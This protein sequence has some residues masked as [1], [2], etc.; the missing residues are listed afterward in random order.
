[1]LRR[2]RVALY[3]PH[4]SEYS[5]RLAAGLARHCDV[6]LVLNRKDANR[7][8]SL[9]AIP[10]SASFELRIRDLSLR[11]SG[12]LG[13]PR[14]FL[15]VLTF[16]P[17]I[18]H[19]HESPDYYT[20]VLIEVLRLSRTPLVL[21]VHDA[22]P[23]SDG[24]SGTNRVEELLRGRMRSA[25]ALVTLH[26]NRCVAEF[27][28]TSPDFKGRLTAAMHGVLMVPPS[29]AAPIQPVTGRILLFGR[30][31]S[32]KGL[33]VFL[34]AVDILAKRG[35]QHQAVVA[36]RGPEMTRLAARIASAPT[37][38]AIDAYISPEETGVLFRSAAVVA[39][40]YK[41]ATQSGVLASAFGNHRAVVA[42]A[43]GGIPDIVEDGSNG[44]LVPPG[45]PV[46][47]ADALQR[48]LQ[49]PEV[50]AELTAG[51]ARTAAGAM[52]WDHIADE[53]HQAYKALIAC[54][55]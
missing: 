28:L 51:A 31:M 14:S 49:S 2:L 36:G 29:N 45:D 52:N 54:P 46:A 55:S 7:Q 44:I 53:V 20:A 10:V 25:A 26:G 24:G 19:C 1:M 17:D 38:R 23:H 50:L 30:M 42:S 6:R 41:D 34:D 15:D 27:Q 4:F 8:W 16:R 35:V 33:D 48:L 39:L 43:T 40:P 3:A 37:V 47:L 22:S 21:T 11:R 9:A 13:I 12:V 18:V 5:F 32:Y